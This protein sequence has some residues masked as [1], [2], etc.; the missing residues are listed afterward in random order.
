M[1]LSDIQPLDDRVVVVRDTAEGVTKG[2]LILPDAVKEKPQKGTIIATGPG[3]LIDNR[4]D[5]A[6]SNMLV[7]PGDVVIFGRYSGTELEVEGKS[8]V[9]MRQSDVQAIVGHQDL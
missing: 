8:I 6:V 1:K 5:G 4:E 7:S 2:G 3:R 9:I